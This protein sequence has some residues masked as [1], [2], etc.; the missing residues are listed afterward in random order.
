M[1]IKETRLAWLAGIIDGEG[2]IGFYEIPSN[3]TGVT[4]QNHI[5]V[6]NSDPDIIAECDDIITTILG[7]RVTHGRD[8]RKDRPH[9][10]WYISINHQKDIIKVMSLI[11]PYMVGK[12]S[13]AELLVEMLKRH[14]RGTRMNKMECEII[15]ILKRMKREK[16]APT[17]KDIKASMASEL[18]PVNPKELEHRKQLG[19]MQSEMPFE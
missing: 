12:K 10:Y 16:M 18:Y 9:I 1:E 3:K 11:I 7:H 19:T 13:Q 4:Y 8:M 17:S 5:R 2:V 15:D 6:I 14:H